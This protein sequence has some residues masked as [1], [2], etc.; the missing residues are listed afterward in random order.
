MHGRTRERRGRARYVLQD[1][2]NRPHLLYDI[3]SLGVLPPGDV[4]KAADSRRPAGRHGAPPWPPRGS[5]AGR[6][7]QGARG[8][9]VII[10][11]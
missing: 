4:Y 11:N 8:R 5:S 7:K 3:S 2:L 10:A 6:H 9:A 1:P